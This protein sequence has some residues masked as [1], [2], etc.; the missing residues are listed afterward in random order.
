MNT[1]DFVTGSGDIIPI[2]YI[3]PCDLVEYLM[4]YHPGVLVGGLQT[5]TDRAHNL[6]AFWEG[7]RL[8]NGDHQVYREH[9]DNLSRVLPLFWHGDEGRG[10]RRGNTVV[11][12]CQ[13]PFGTSTAL[14][15]KKRTATGDCKC[16]PPASIKQRF[17]SGRQI[18]SQRHMEI[19]EMQTTTMKGHS[20]LHHW[21][22]FIIPSSVHHAHPSAL[23]EMLQI[24]SRDFKRLFYDG[25]TVRGKTYNVSIIGAK[26]DL[27]WFSKIALQRSWENQ[28]RVRDI[29][30]CHE[31]MAG[32][33]G[34][35][36]EDVTSDV[37][38]WS[39]SRFSI[40]PW[41]DAPCVLEIPYCRTAPEKHFKKD[42]FHLCKVGIYRDVV[43]SIVHFLVSYNYFGTRGDYDSKLATAHMGFIL[44]CRT[45]GRTPALRSFTRRLFMLPRLDSY[46]WT[47]TKGSDT[48]LILAWL[49]VQLRGFE[50]SPL[51]ASH[52]RNLQIM[53]ETCKSAINVFRHLNNHNLWH[54]RNCSMIFYTELQSFLRGYSFLAATFLNEPCNGFAIKPKLHLLRHISLEVQ[55]GLTAGLPYQLSCNSQNCEP[56]ED[57]I[58]RTCRLSR[59]LDSR[60]IGERVL[61]CCMLKAGILYARFRKTK[62]I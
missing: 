2:T 61:G 49:Q 29:P 9:S 34:L 25:F 48:M 7:F 13:T 56:N 18:L 31:C 21:P 19:L 58:G 32:S 24:M 10:K 1:Y 36:F 40:R 45:V 60:K 28:G 42:I 15:W 35:P 33:A 37:P 38:V 5:D 4:T 16:S 62:K 59:R 39:A 11:V 52:I 26:G 22:L 44:Y 46:P 23:I 47:N 57:F 27:K 54:S 55:E 14:N 6:E 30:C 51:D 17:G 41:T 8:Q 3:S 50:L 20:F 53:R 12:S 43:G